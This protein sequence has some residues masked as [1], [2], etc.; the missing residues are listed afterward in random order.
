MRLLELFAPLSA[1]EEEAAL[2]K[3]IAERNALGLTSIRDLSLLPQGIQT[4]FRLWQKGQLNMRVSA[5]LDV[6]DL[7]RFEEILTAWGVGSGFGDKWLRL[8]SISEDPHA[9]SIGDTDR[10]KAFSIL[11]NK[12]GWR[13]AAHTGNR[14]GSLTATLA[15]FEA[16]DKASPIKDKRWVIEHATDPTPA[17][18][19]QM[20]RLGVMVSATFAGYDSRPTPTMD[21]ETRAFLENQTPTRTYI[22]K[23]LIVSAGT[24]FLTRVA[25]DDNPFTPFYF[26]VTRK[27]RTGQVLGPQH[28]ITRE[29]ALRVSTINFAYTTFEEKVK[30][31]L[32]PGKLADFLILSDDVMTVAEEKIL[33]IR[34]LA[35]YVGGKKVFAAQGGGF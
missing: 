22:D 3:A 23:G 24:D 33:S 15:G 31:S 11:A 14:D 30:G 17:Q 4:Y 20:K 29:E 9:E 13:L 16:A 21:A 32:E 2:L 34:P 18:I 1:A 35:T 10:M 8:D 12:Y 6:P 26:N 25:P 7:D 28:R 19:D 5:A 27:T